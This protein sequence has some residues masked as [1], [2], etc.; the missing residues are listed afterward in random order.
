MGGRFRYSRWDGSQHLDDLDPDAVLE[1]LSDDLMSYG[2]LS[3]ALQRLYRW[4]SD[5]L[6]GLEQLL[7]ELRERR[8]QELSRYDL[9]SAVE[10]IRQRLQ[11]V[12]DTE[13]SGMDRKRHDAPT[14]AKRGLERMARQGQ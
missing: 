2:D 5:D 10:D 3:A 4:G 9:D 12:I 8:E 7:R 13:R 1:S 11:D 6:P 14:E